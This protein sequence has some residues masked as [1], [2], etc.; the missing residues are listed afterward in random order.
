MDMNLAVGMASDNEMA[1]A[2]EELVALFKMDEKI[3]RLCA[4][5]VGGVEH[6]RN[7][8]PATAFNRYK[9]IVVSSF[10]SLNLRRDIRKIISES[11]D[12][13]NFKEFIDSLRGSKIS[14]MSQ[15]EEDA[16]SPDVMLDMQAFFSGLQA[17][18]PT[19]DRKRLIEGI[20]KVKH[21]SS[22]V[23]NTQIELFRVITRGT[24][25]LRGAD[26]K[27][28]EDQLNQTVSSMKKEMGA[29]IERQVW[30]GMLYAYKDISDADLESYLLLCET[31][32]VK[33]VDGFMREAYLSM[34]ENVVNTLQY[35]LRLVF[36]CYSNN[37]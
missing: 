10:D 1:G 24:R 14:L 27:A 23:V 28:S 30:T 16:K 7:S 18:P 33:S 37:A 17:S 20:D 2:I 35:E 5:V 4:S 12:V 8:I 3:D 21:F 31:D 13:D 11:Y 22:I 19:E 9:E 15:C 36:D 26:L 29:H 32:S 6:D 25:G 34:H